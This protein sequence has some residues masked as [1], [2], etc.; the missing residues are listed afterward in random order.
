MNQ[1]QL[2][3]SLAQ[4]F[5][6]H[7]YSID[8]V[9]LITYEVDAGF[10]RG[11]PDGVFFPESTAD[12]SRI[13]TWAKKTGTRLIARGGGTGLAGGAVAEDGGFVLSFARMNTIGTVDPIGRSVAV[14]V[15]A[16]NL[17]VDAVVKRCGL[18][19]PPDPSSQRTSTIGGNMGTNAGGPHCLK[20]GV[21]TNYITG[22]RA[23]LAD[24]TSMRFGGQALDYPEYD[25]CGV[26]VGSEGTLA[27]MTEVDLRLVPNPSG[28]KTMMAAFASLEEA[29]EAVS[30]VIATGLLPATL[31]MMDQAAMRMIT[32]YAPAGLPVDAAAA[33]I[34]E[35]D[36][37]PSG[38]DSQMEEIADLLSANGGFD[39][40]IAQTDEERAQIWYGRKSAAGALARLS[41]QFYLTDVTVP[42]SQLSDMLH[43]VIEICNQHDLQMMNVFHAG[44]GNLHPL[45]LCDQTNAELMERVHAASK[46]II[47]RCV[48]RDGSIS[49][50]HGIGIEKR[51]Y[52]KTMFGPNEL[53]GMA[54]MQEVFD[55]QRRLNPGKVIPTDLE[56]PIF[57]PAILP[58]STVFAPPT[59][60][61]AASALRALSDAGIQ[62]QITGDTASPANTSINEN[63]SE[64]ALSTSLLN[65]VI[66]FAPDDLYITVGAGMRVSDLDAFLADYKLKTAIAAPH[67]DATVGG[68]LAANVNA[69]HR[70]RYDGLRNNLLCATIALADGRVMRAGRPLVK[71]VAGYDLPKLFVGSYG[72]LGVMIDVTLKLHPA[73][74][75][76][77]TVAVKLTTLQDA[78]QLAH[79]ILPLALNCAGLTISNQGGTNQPFKLVFTAEGMEEEVAAE[80]ETVAQCAAEA[81]AG[82]L[83]KLAFSSATQEW[84]AFMGDVIDTS[85][86]VRVGV[87]SAALPTY[88]KMIGLD[89]GSLPSESG[90]FLLDIGAGFLYLKQACKSMAEAR[91]LLDRLRRPFSDSVRPMDGYALV[92]RQPQSHEWRANRSGIDWRGYQPDST[93]LMLELK[94]CWDPNGILKSPF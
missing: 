66:H 77:S 50:E 42:R 51:A 29:G 13:V 15:G 52:M 8:P 33:L 49:G 92:I 73:P 71:N 11:R 19:Y 94:Q 10:D 89:N 44:D 93:D 16:V 91:A 82:D 62:V 30:A 40:R 68:V 39:L 26:L 12:V 81:G 70:A 34:V 21:T 64:Y 78:V 41:P 83:K 35:V 25:F 67:L 1:T 74:R 5:Q 75:A 18:Y 28:V 6:P 80:L 69:P 85:L 9:E 58:T 63:D 47:Q 84:G 31:E 76:K 38:V 65:E 24:G 37:H 7:Q 56:P 23:V 3:H 59:V 86:I 46:K 48:D 4:T 27:I 55:P 61:E 88:L 36:G 43:D 54:Q 79:W 14:Q 32:E 72:S 60:T 53:Y 45:I 90:S 2:T 57:E 20:Y 22:I 87:P 17:D